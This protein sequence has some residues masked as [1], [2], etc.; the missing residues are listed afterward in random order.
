M[1]FLK[2]DINVLINVNLKLVQVSAGSTNI[3]FP[4][5][6]HAQCVQM[7][8]F[9]AKVPRFD[10]F[11]PLS[12]IDFWISRNAGKPKKWRILTFSKFYVVKFIFL[13]K[14]KRS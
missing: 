4:F 2:K 9:C 10:A 12:R 14:I 3:P 7:L 5:L 8:W 11:D 1:F 6:P 13:L